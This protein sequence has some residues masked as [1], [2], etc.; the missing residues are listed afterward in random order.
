MNGS[1]SPKTRVVP[2]ARRRARE[3]SVSLAT[4]T[5]TGVGGRLTVA[6]VERAAAARSV[7]GGRDLPS[8]VDPA[9][10]PSRSDPPAT[11]V[12]RKLASERGIDL[13]AVSGTGPGGRITK[14]DVHA[15]ASAIAVTP[16][17]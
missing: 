11:P 6:D 10:D 3:L 14:D 17:G 15:H 1:V 13:A 7:P 9:A 4:V 5:P 2:A 8:H 16:D 12:A